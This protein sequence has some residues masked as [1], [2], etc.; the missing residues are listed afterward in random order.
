MANET[1]MDVAEFDMPDG[2]VVEFD[3]PKGM[4]EQQIQQL[5]RQYVRD[6]PDFLQQF[7]APAQTTPSVV[8]PALQ[9]ISGQQ[10]QHEPFSVQQ[11]LLNLW[12]FINTP[13]DVLTTVA[14]STAGDIFGGLMGVGEALRTGDA[15]RGEMLQEAVQERFQ[16]T[17]T[18]R[19]GQAIMQ[20]T[21][22]S[23]MFQAIN[24]AM[25]SVEQRLADMGFDTQS[26][27][28][29]TALAVALPTAIGE[30]FS[31]GVPGNVSRAARAPLQARAQVLEQQASDLH[32]R[33]E[34][35]RAVTT[36]DTDLPR[37]DA[38]DITT[39]T[40]RTTTTT[41][42][43]EGPPQPT[44]ETPTETIETT[45]Q[46]DTT[47]DV[48]LTFD[49]Q[50][51]K[52][53]DIISKGDPEEVMTE[54]RV[55]PEFYKAVD[56]LG[57]ST[58]PLA[59]FASQNPQF[60]SIE[61]GLAGLS[62]SQIDARNKQFIAELAQKADDLISQYG[63]TLDKGELSQRFKSE[64]LDK[65]EDLAQQADD[66]YNDLEK[67]I[68][69]PT[70]IEAPQNIL[71]FI[72][73]QAAEMGGRE[74]MTPMMKELD[75]QLRPAQRIDPETG[76]PTVITELPTFGMLNKLRRDV[77]EAL[78]KSKGKFRSEQEGFLKEVYRNL[79][80]DQ[81]EIAKQM[82]VADVSKAADGLLIQRKQL[83]DNTK[84]LLG[85]DLNNSVVARI[86]SE[87]KGLGERGQIDKFK[88]AMAAI[89]NKKMREQVVTTA[90]NDVMSGKGLDQRALSTSNFAKFMQK[91]NAQPTLKNALYDE[92]RP[93]ARKTLDAMGKISIGISRALQDRIPTG[94]VLQFLNPKTGVMNRM[95]KHGARVAG[96]QA[97]DPTG[98]MLTETAV[99]QVLNR[100]NT[101]A[102]AV[103]D[104]LG[105]SQ[106]QNI[107]RQAVRDG[108]DQGTRISK[109]VEKA[110]A[111][112]ARSKIYKD[113]AKS[114]NPTQ[115]GQLASL[116]L[117]NYLLDPDLP[118]TDQENQPQ[119]PLRAAN[120]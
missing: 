20:K 105:S 96:M 79:R 47:V 89:P 38:E 55:N 107:I 81:D 112:F 33:A 87:I 108:V 116:G 56:E 106:F 29:R 1:E 9:G 5:F 94:R 98:G 115:Q 24:N 19:G 17:P 18:T 36:G 51:Q 75:S 69:G 72:D 4:N 90:L 88:A 8:P 15:G 92:L 71:A 23:E 61:Q 26:G 86:G 28:L 65:I 54:A 6:N 52:V 30:L 16:R 34:N 12:D 21:A 46:T 3:V 73:K 49:E 120:Q 14:S 48:P 11:A 85:R 2:S 118:T 13:R 103:A 74:K 50:M 110:Q 100:K 102:S 117:V 45:L 66:L 44:V 78:N 101:N 62:G 99:E 39:A 43:Q 84:F 83:E 67:A 63:G 93:E 64:S 32:R 40:T 109:T 60:R 25:Q 37:P 91:L 10:V 104:L 114:L 76:R 68:P 42:P 7:Q 113:W 35:L 31:L 77:G 41:T 59:S 95:V 80:L 53:A 57:M 27:P 97:G 82:G 70:R 22:E 119:P 111:K 58:E